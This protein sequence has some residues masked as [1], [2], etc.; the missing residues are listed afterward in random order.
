MASTA[1]QQWHAQVG[2]YMYDR[3]HK[4]SVIPNLAIPPG[5][6]PLV[7]AA[8]HHGMRVDPYTFRTDMQ[9]LPSVCQGNASLEFMPYFALGVDGVFADYPSHGVFAR[10]MFQQ[11]VSRV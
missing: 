5:R 4:S 10:Q 2:C 8:H 7:E 11:W 1:C 9:F 6:A 3:P